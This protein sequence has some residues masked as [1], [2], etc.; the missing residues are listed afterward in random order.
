[1]DVSNLSV[2]RLRASVRSMALCVFLFFGDSSPRECP[3]PPFLSD[4]LSLVYT[5]TSHIVVV[6]AFLFVGFRSFLQSFCVRCLSAMGA[7]VCLSVFP[8]GY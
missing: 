4:R 3:Q 1:M 5:H 7:R 2:A 6:A 8:I